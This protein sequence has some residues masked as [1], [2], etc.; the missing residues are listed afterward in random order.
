MLSMV[1]ALVYSLDV[2]RQVVDLF[3]VLVRNDRTRSG[4]RISTQNHAI[5]EYDAGN[6]GAGLGRLGRLET[7]LQHQRVPVG[8][9]K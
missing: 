5:L 6:G 1:V 7:I 9:R 4:S 3:A 2:G 8:E